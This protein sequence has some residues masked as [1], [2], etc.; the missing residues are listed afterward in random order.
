MNFKACFVCCIFSLFVGT[1]MSAQDADN[2]IGEKNEIGLIAGVTF[3]PG[4]ALSPGSILPGGDSSLTSKPSLALGVDYDRHILSLDWFAV[5]G[6]VD[7]L[8]SPFDVKLSQAPVNASPQYA[9][10]F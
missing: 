4:R 10:L 2:P 1:T 7:F 5:Y 6:G 8:A 3:T 9:Y